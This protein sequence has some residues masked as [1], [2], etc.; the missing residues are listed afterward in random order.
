MKANFRLIS[1]AQHPAP[2]AVLQRVL[3]YPDELYRV[4]DSYGKLRVVA[5]IALVTQAARDL[6]IGPGH[7]ARL[8]RGHDVALISPLRSDQL[9][10]ELYADQPIQ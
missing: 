5:G 2:Q 9:I 3:L 1:P 8:D 4:P 10:V 7:E 6:I